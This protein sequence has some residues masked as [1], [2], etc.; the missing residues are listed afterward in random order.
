MTISSASSSSPV[1]AVAAGRRRKWPVYVLSTGPLC[2]A[3]ISVIFLIASMPACRI[4]LYNNDTKNKIN[5]KISIVN[6][7]DIFI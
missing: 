1:G 5:K 7:D 6:D 2:V 4:I 3:R